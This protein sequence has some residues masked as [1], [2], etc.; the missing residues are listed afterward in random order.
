M[1][2]G[3]RKVTFMNL[4]VSATSGMFLG[5]YIILVMIVQHGFDI[6]VYRVLCSV[7]TILMSLLYSLYCTTYH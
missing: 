1:T 5:N 7:R 3:N 4:Q 2:F 6:R